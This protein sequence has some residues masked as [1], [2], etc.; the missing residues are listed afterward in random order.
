MK[1]EKVLNEA[2]IYFEALNSGS[3]SILNSIT[4]YFSP[5]EPNGFQKDYPQFAKWI[6]SVYSTPNY[7]Y[8]RKG[9]QFYAV[10]IELNTKW[11]NIPSIDEKIYL[12]EVIKKTSIVQDNSAITEYK[13]GDN[14]IRILIK[15]DAT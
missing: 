7:L 9:A 2:N 1:I 14:I 4:D 13:D 5:D 15:G 11:P 8:K 10:M 12:K 3:I 6:F